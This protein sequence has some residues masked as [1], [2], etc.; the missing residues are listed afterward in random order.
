MT[1]NPTAHTTFKEHNEMILSQ[2]GLHKARFDEL[3]ADSVKLR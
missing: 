3:T 2:T 1:F